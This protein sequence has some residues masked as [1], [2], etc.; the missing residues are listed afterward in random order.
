MKWIEQ[1]WKRNEQHVGYSA[2]YML[3]NFTIER[4]EGAAFLSLDYLDGLIKFLGFESG[5]IS[6]MHP[7][8]GICRC[9]SFQVSE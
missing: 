2:F 7:K 1:L 8:Y 3:I 9:V 5:Y 6:D 4:P